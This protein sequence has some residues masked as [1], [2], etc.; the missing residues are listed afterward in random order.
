M[1]EVLV[2][3]LLTTIYCLC[4]IVYATR[5]SWS[6]RQ[7]QRIVDLL[8]LAVLLMTVDE[9]PSLILLILLI[10]RHFYSNVASW[11]TLIKQII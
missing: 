2:P 11:F 9:Q 6:M 4:I 10:C 8:R 7:E 1:T 5:C 3:R